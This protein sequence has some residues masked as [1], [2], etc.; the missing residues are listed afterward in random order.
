MKTGKHSVVIGN[1]PGDSTIGEGSVV[2][3]ATDAN[4]NTILNMPMAVGYRA[5]AGAGSIAIGAF[6]GAGAPD[7]HFPAEVGTE[8]RE[9]VEIAVRSANRELLA[10]LHDLASTLQQ[11]K[12]EGSAVLAAWEGVKAVATIDGASNLLARAT[13][14]LLAYLGQGGA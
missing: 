9:L 10:A 11:P 3:G 5:R 7:L 6:A 14:A 13:T 12:S 2:I 4:G 8:M 1:V